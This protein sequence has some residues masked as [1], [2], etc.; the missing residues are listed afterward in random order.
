MPG[1]EAVESR[2]LT[3][4]ARSDGPTALREMPGNTQGVWRDGK[5]GAESAGCLV[6]LADAEGAESLVSHN[7]RARAEGSH[8]PEPCA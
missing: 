1:T 8:T 4:S 5:A 3:V 7:S 6:R 2:G